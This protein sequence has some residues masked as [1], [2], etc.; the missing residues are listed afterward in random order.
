M[1]VEKKEHT[2]QQKELRG[3][4]IVKQFPGQRIRVAAA[5]E[6][7][8]KII[9]TLLCFDLLRRVN[10]QFVWFCKVKALTLKLKLITFNLFLHLMMLVM[11]AS[12]NWFLQLWSREWREQSDLVREKPSAVSDQSVLIKCSWS[13]IMTNYIINREESRWIADSFSHLGISREK[14][15]ILIGMCHRGS[16]RVASPKLPRTIEMQRS[17]DERVRRAERNKI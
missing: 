14:K 9:I 11:Q 15:W 17:L 16:E 2:Q 13:E 6:G 3:S 12:C 8:W 5:R 1:T 4:L 7:H 10:T